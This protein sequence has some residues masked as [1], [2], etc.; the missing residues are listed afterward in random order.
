M[1]ENNQSIANKNNSFINKK[2]GSKKSEEGSNE[3]ETA[4][5]DE[6][7]NPLDKSKVMEE[8]DDKDEFVGIELDVPS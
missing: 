1:K 3:S 6:H 8:Y 2:N 7:A 5:D 4:S